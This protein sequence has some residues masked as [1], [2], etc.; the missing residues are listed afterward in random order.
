[1]FGETCRATRRNPTTMQHSTHH[2]PLRPLFSLS[3]IRGPPNARPRT[4][5][6]PPA[7]EVPR[8]RALGGTSR[9]TKTV[10]RH[11]Q[12]HCERGPTRPG[13][14]ARHRAKRIDPIQHHVRH[15]DAVQDQPAHWSAASRGHF[16]AAASPA[17][18]SGTSKT[19]CSSRTAVT[20]T[21]LPARLPCTCS[22]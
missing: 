13:Q 10:Q 21:R 12:Q 3:P 1:M 7:R 17:G 4:A 16:S 8:K 14:S 18:T 20:A 5:T 15:P 6:T 19:S 11:W 9:S 2:W 22:S